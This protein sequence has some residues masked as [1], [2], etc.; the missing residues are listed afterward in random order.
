MATPVTTQSTTSTPSTVLNI[1]T[2]EEE[3]GDIF[4]QLVECTN[5]FNSTRDNIVEF[6]NGIQDI[7]HPKNFKNIREKFNEM[8]LYEL[9][10]SG[11]NKLVEHKLNELYEQSESKYR[12]D[13]RT[14]V[15]LQL[16]REKLEIKRL[17]N[18]G[19]NHV[20]SLDKPV[21]IPVSSVFMTAQEP[22]YYYYKSV[23]DKPDTYIQCG[24]HKT[25]M[26][27]LAVKCRTFC[28]SYTHNDIES[29][30][31]VIIDTIVVLPNK[32]LLFLND[33]K[34]LQHT[35]QGGSGAVGYNYIGYVP[36]MTWSLTHNKEKSYSDSGGIFNTVK[37]NVFDLCEFVKNNKLSTCDVI[38]YDIIVKTQH[39][40]NLMVKQPDPRS[41]HND[42]T[43]GF[44]QTHHPNVYIK[45]TLSFEGYTHDQLT[46]IF[47]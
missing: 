19:P 39:E 9:K 42:R 40:D 13:K 29:N 5:E 36:S 22:V 43:I 12:E 31:C 38:Y 2:C 11:I 7:D 30:S 4:K 45:F 28:A 15:K 20:V 1:T 46:E 34:Y 3:F 24:E 21:T 17:E 26:K 23:H 10:I 44:T 25:D 35:Y 14:L 33:C 32:Q 41:Y 27:Y 37:T 47:A 18:P 16:E 8:K 6:V